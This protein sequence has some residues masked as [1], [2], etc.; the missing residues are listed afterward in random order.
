MENIQK[1][2]RINIAWYWLANPQDSPGENPPNLICQK[3]RENW[4][5][6]APVARGILE[7]K[8]LRHFKQIFYL[9]TI[10]CDGLSP[11]LGG[12]GRGGLHNSRAKKCRTLR[13]GAPGTGAAERQNPRPLQGDPWW[14]P[15][16]RH[17]LQ[18]I[19]AASTPTTSWHPREPLSSWRTTSRS[20]W[21]NS[22]RSSR[23]RG[24]RPQSAS[25][26][27]LARMP[28]CSCN[29]SAC[30]VQPTPWWESLSWEGKLKGKLIIFLFF[31]INFSYQIVTLKVK[32]VVTRR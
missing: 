31:L 23:Q 5:G 4:P 25:L 11:R 26:S 18:A 2:L 14:Q 3:I 1:G 9:F 7:R 17:Q 8:H 30:L 15:Y 6:W 28:G 16:P 13:H 21:T 24:T 10:T 22:W 29:C 20:R 12:D 27:W 32:I 19:W